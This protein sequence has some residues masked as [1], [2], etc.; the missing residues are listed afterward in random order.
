VLQTLDLSRRIYADFFASGGAAA[1][2]DEFPATRGVKH[3]IFRDIG[4]LRDRG[5]LQIQDLADAIPVRVERMEEG[6]VEAVVY[7]EWN[8]LV[9]YAA[10]RRPASEVLGLGGGF[11]Y[12]LSRDA[13]GR[14]TI[15]S[16][17][18]VPMTKP[19]HPPEF[20]Y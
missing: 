8:Y 10:D 2:L 20:K 5:V 16:W 3:R 14:W 4:F 15:T 13:S 7:E 12:L 19:P 11:R 9:Q 18:P 1:L 17:E 6:T